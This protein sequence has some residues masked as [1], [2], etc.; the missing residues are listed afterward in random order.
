MEAGA[1][2]L[3][4]LIIIFVAIVGGSLWLLTST[5]R[6][7][8]LNPDEDKI[9]SSMLASGLVEGE[10]N[11]DARHDG[12]ANGEAGHDR[13]VRPEHTR[14]ANEQRSRSMPRR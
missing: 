6:R 13:D 9:D 10:P 5:L 4:L 2:F 14:V 12:L 1:A 7:R 8:K 3:L 11:G